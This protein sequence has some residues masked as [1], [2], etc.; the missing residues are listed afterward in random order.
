MA[1]RIRSHHKRSGCLDI[2]ENLI[3]FLIIQIEVSPTVRDVCL[4]SFKRIKIVVILTSLCKQHSQFQ[5]RN[6]FVLI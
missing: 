1:Y 4:E 6:V 3:C 2:A 5:L